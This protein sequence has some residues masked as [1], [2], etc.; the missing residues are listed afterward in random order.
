MGVLTVEFLVLVFSG[1][2]VLFL[3]YFTHVDVL[4]P[5]KH[6]QTQARTRAPRQFDLKRWKCSNIY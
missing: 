4:K 1:M 5:C 6:I 2:E 3:D